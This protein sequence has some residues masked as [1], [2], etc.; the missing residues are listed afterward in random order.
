MLALLAVHG[1]G[2][3]RLMTCQP[4]WLHV[5]VDIVEDSAERTKTHREAVTYRHMDESKRS[6]KRKSRSVV[7][8]ADVARTIR[9]AKQAEAPAVE[10]TVEGTTRVLLG[11][12]EKSPEAANW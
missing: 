6:N 4:A 5:P 10:V 1:I 3:A 9:V 12:P 11:A 8:Q 2:Y 7:T